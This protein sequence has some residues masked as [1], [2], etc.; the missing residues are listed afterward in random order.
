MKE[1]I[2]DYLKQYPKDE[3]PLNYSFAFGFEEIEKM[4]REREGRR[5]VCIS[6]MDT[7]DGG[8]LGYAD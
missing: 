2:E 1:L 7:D 3:S 5:I 8:T 6:D 4:L